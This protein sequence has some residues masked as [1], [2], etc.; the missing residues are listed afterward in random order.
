MGPNSIVRL[1]QRGQRRHP[2]VQG[3]TVG[4]GSPDRSGQP[5]SRDTGDRAERGSREGRMRIQARPGPDPALWSPLPSAICVYVGT[6]KHF[7]S[8]KSKKARRFVIFDAEK[9]RVIFST[10]F[11]PQL[12]QPP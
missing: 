5:P 12:P 11:Y 4:R 3:R 10:F 9:G 1:V 7:F 6:R 2:G 8:S